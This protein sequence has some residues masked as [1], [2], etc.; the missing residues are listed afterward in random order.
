MPYYQCSKC[1][2]AAEDSQRLCLKHRAEANAER[3]QKASEMFDYYADCTTIDQH[4]RQQW[5]LARWYVK[6]ILR[7]VDYYQDM[8]NR[9]DIAISELNEKIEKL[10]E[11][12]AERNNEISELK[13]E[14]EFQSFLESE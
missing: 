4:M 5:N 14:I 10:R 12:I 9:K 2:R 11:T 8:S 6:R 3:E 7:R 1:H 13:Q